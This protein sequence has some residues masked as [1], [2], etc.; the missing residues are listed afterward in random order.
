MT[1]FKGTK[2]EW[3]K[4]GVHSISRNECVTITST[5][6]SIASVHTLFDG[7]DNYSKAIE[8][9][10]N[11][12]LIVDAGNTINKCD[13][14]PSE[15]LEQRNELLKTLQDFWELIVEKEVSTPISM[16]KQIEDIISKSLG[17]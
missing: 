10:S 11:A 3:V 12:Q 9:E 16:Q 5:V 4:K 2:G 15:L 6:D 17:K 8:A 14:M 13:L 1:K 7:I